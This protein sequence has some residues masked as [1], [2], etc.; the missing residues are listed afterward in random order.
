[1]YLSSS[2]SV[3]VQVTQPQSRGL[4]PV[5]V[6]VPELRQCLLRCAAVTGYSGV[7]TARDVEV[8]VVL[9]FAAGHGDGAR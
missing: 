4:L 8:R 2:A 6:Q 9:L 7:G 5:P 3:S 1:M